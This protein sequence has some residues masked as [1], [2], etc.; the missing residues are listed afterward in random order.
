MES[1]VALAVLAIPVLLIVALSSVSTVKRR[2]GMLEEEVDRLR[3][4]VALQTPPPEP[5]ATPA[6]PREPHAAPSAAP[7]AERVAQPTPPAP[8]SID[9]K[10]PPAAAEPRAPEA[11]PTRL[12]YVRPVLQPS[13]LDVAMR[14]LQRWFTVGNVP[15]KIG[16]LV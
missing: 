16:M 12:P 1:V 6:T 10:L 15:V 14:A 5:R 4:Q 7:V 8:S 2:L 3:M 9:A 13:M 11:L